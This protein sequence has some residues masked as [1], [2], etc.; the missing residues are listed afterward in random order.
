M[1]D[2]TNSAAIA[3]TLQNRSRG[4]KLVTDMSWLYCYSF[5]LEPEQH[6]PSGT[7][8]FSRIDTAHLQMALQSDETSSGGNV[9]RNCRIYAI[10]YNVLRIMSGMGGMA[11]SG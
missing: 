2:N 7:C 6:Q 1:F 9:A 10:N 4:S 11:Y 3:V 5:A 8:N